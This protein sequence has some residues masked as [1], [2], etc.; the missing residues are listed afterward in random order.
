MPA[1]VM[2]EVLSQYHPQ[3]FKVDQNAPMVGNETITIPSNGLI[4]PIIRFR[5]PRKANWF[6]DAFPL[7]FMKLRNASNVEL[8]KTAK[9]HVGFKHPVESAP[10]WVSN[11]SY[12]PWGNVPYANQFDANFQ[13]LLHLSLKSGYRL[14]EDTEIWLGVSQNSGSSFTISWANCDFMFEIKQT[15]V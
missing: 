7:I 9:I 3:A 2:K 5:V 10:T 4:T 6:V 1:N 11:D 14:E 12:A 8:P 15:L 13:A